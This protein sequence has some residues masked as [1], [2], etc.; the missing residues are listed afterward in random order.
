MSN[1]R[2]RSSHY[3]LVYRDS[4]HVVRQIPVTINHRGV[5]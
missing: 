3:V 4:A 1:L 2:N 5:A